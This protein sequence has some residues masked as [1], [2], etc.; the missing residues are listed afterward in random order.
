MLHKLVGYF[1]VLL[2]LL[3]GGCVV[4]DPYPGYYD[5]PQYRYPRYQYWGPPIQFR[6]NYY[7]GWHGLNQEDGI[8]SP[9][10][11]LGYQD[12]PLMC[13]D[14]KNLALPTG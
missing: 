4:Y 3:L 5:Y 7:R 10:F 11:R 13:I 12:E 8:T 9:A 6:Y 2:F 1:L 14:P